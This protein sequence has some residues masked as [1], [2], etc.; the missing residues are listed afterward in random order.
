MPGCMAA[1]ERALAAL[2]R[3]ELHL[4]LRPVVE[5]PGESHFLGLMP[6]FRGGDRPL[7]ALKT[8]AVFP[9][10]PAR[11]LDPH[12]GTVT[13]FDGETGQ[14]LAVMNATPDHRDPHGR[15]V[16]RGNPRAGAGG[17]ARPGDRRRRPPGAAARA[18]RCSRRGR[19]SEI[20][21]S[22][23]DARERRAARRRVA[24]RPRGRRPARRR[25]AAPMSICTVTQLRAS[26]SLEARVAR[27]G[28]AHQRG[29]RLPAA[30]ARARR[31]DRRALVA[32][33][34]TGASRRE[35]GR[36]LPPRPAGRR[37]RRRSHQG[38]ARRG[39]R[40]AS[41]PAARPT[42]E[43]T[44][45]E[46]LGLA[47]EDLAAAE[48]VDAPRRGDAAP[49]RRSSFDPAGRDRARARADRRRGHPHAARPR[50][51]PTR[52]DIWLKLE[53]L[54]PIGSFKIR[55]ATNAIRAASPERA[56]RRASS[57]RAPG[58]MAQ[59]VAWAAREAGVPGDR[60]SSPTTR[61]RRS[62]TRSSGSAAA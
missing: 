60:S 21:I 5:P 30:H 19:S 32:S 57:P 24:G 35:R 55:G 33:S 38:R 22:S 41:R 45:F 9:D 12:Q 6:T 23:A 37:D 61:R 39:A 8:V 59:G 20:R 42:D 25:S 14:V 44:V 58:N 34:S 16:R 13:L 11:G 54:Q 10:N 3:G 28:R 51:S 47:V 1:M 26:R 31:R 62:S 18:R 7:Y 40:P 48:Y 56:R 43:I 17:R 50:C 2:A 27:A 53:N 46:S 36:R 15:G 29:R 4:P 52:G 49:A